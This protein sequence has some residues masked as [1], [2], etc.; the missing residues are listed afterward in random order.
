MRPEPVESSFRRDPS[1]S[2]RQF[3]PVTGD[4][5][6]HDDR[7]AFAEFKF[8]AIRN[9][10]AT[11]FSPPKS[12][13]KALSRM[14]SKSKTRASSPEFRDR[15]GACPI[16]VSTVRSPTWFSLHVRRVRGGRVAVDPHRRFSRLA[17]D[18]K[19]VVPCRPPSRDRSGGGASVVRGDLSA[20]HFGNE[21]SGTRWG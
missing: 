4:Q 10:H 15:H 8:Q 18:P 7:S 16:P 6:S 17:M 20:H 12:P 13:R 5:G 11:S 14:N 3:S 2:F 1:V 19:S 21:S 9:V